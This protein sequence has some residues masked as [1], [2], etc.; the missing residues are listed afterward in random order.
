MEAAGRRPDDSNQLLLTSEAQ[1]AAK[2][3]AVAQVVEGPVSARWPGSVLQMH[4]HAT[5][6][7]DR[8]AASELELFDY[9]LDVHPE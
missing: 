3:R 2:A 5:L 7:L 8:A 6:V 1:R 4:R 9:Y